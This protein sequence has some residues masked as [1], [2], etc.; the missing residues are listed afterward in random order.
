[1]HTQILGCKLKADPHKKSR[2]HYFKEKF[3]AQLELKNY[4]SG[5]GW[6]TRQCVTMD[7]STWV[8]YVKTRP[9]AKL[10]KVT[11]EVI[12]HKTTSNIAMIATSFCM[13]DSLDERCQYLYDELSNFSELSHHQ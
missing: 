2:H 5:L 3:V 1:M 6:E 13:D 9:N 8:G 12:S 10:F 11:W 7:D 4:A